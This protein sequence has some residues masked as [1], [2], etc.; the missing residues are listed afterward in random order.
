MTADRDTTAANLIT[1]LNSSP[2]LPLYSSLE[3]DSI[4]LLHYFPSIFATNYE[5]V[6]SKHGGACPVAGHCSE[7]ETERERERERESALSQRKLISHAFGV[8]RRIA[9]S[10]VRLQLPISKIAEYKI[11]RCRSTLFD[12]S[13]RTRTRT[14]GVQV[15][16]NVS[17]R[18]NRQHGGITFELLRRKTFANCGSRYC[19]LLFSFLLFF[20]FQR[21]LTLE[22]PKMVK[23]A[24]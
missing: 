22:L 1:K 18:S 15:S 5:I 20:L 21:F 8:R 6:I 12:S 10:D 17:G 4:V 19:F 24:K 14:R 2:F 3:R 11:R 13:Y 9:I 23:M 7:R 16:K